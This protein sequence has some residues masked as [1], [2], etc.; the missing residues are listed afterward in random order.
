ML[1]QVDVSKLDAFFFEHWTRQLWDT[2]IS[3]I[4]QIGYFID[5]LHHDEYVDANRDNWAHISV[6]SG[7]STIIDREFVT[8]QV[9]RKYK[10]SEAH[11]NLLTKF[12]F[13]I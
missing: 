6:V 1:V 7:F 2:R 13:I 4:N 8:Q 5:K 3:H 12:I 10:C 9:S 11:S